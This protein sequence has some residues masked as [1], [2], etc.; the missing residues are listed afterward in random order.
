LYEGL[1]NHGLQPYLDCKSIRIGEDCWKSIEDGIKN[2]PIAVVVFSE[3]YAESEWCL[4]E[5]HVMLEA[6]EAQTRSHSCKEILPIFYNVE[7]RDVR[8]PERGKFE[9]GFEKLKGKFEEKIIEEWKAD[10][11][12]ASTLMGWEHSDTSTRYFISIMYHVVK[13]FGC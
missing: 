9:K 7:P 8:N 3:R 2:T 13:W 10:L 12:K 6:R 11:K 1:K 5:L 4:K